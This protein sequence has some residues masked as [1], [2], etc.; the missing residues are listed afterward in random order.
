MA[1]V[2]LARFRIWTCSSERLILR[3]EYNARHTPGHRL[4]LRDVSQT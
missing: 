1:L 4:L 3:V 2:Q